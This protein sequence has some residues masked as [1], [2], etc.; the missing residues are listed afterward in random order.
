MYA[1][2]LVA[3]LLGLS[4]LAAAQNSTSGP[5]N[6][7]DGKVMVH[8]VW[9]GNAN[10]DLVF[11]PETINAK[12]GEM[13]QF[14]F[15]PKNHSVAQS[16]F[17]NPCA[18]ISEGPSSS[19]NSSAGFYSGFMPV[20]ASAPV[21]PVFTIEVKD[22]APIWFYCATGKHCQNGM[23]GVIN[24]PNNPQRTLE[25]YK[26]AAAKVAASKFP[27]AS[28][29]GESGSQ[30]PSDSPDGTTDAPSETTSPSAS[31][32]VRVSLAGLFVAAAM[33][34]FLL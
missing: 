18:P 15:Y 21:Q 11:E 28:A 8:A 22:T 23:V 19:G 13:V 24:P 30:T 32:S 5:E 6:T 4:A 34:V 1:K 20:E 9:V 7:S 10:G 16:S 12:V 2:T 26:A 17:D 33:G 27:G 14:Q 29:G 31:S 3:S 25:N